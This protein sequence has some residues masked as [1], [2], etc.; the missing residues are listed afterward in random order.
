MITSI[1]WRNIWRNKLRSSVLLTAIGIGVFAGVF[2]WAFMQG[3]GKQRVEAAIK[4]EVAHIQIHHP[5]Y[6]TDPN[7]HNYMEDGFWTAEM[8]IDQPYV[9]ATSM[10]LIFPAMVASA[11][12]STGV[13]LRGINPSHERRVTDIHERIVKGQYFEGISRNPIVIG[14]KLA[15]KLK[16]KVRSK[17]VVTLQNMEGEIVKAQ[18]RVAGIFKTTNSTYDQMN[19]FVNERDLASLTGIGRD[20]G[21]EVALIVYE[22]EDIE[23]VREELQGF[24]GDLELKTWD[25]VRPEISLITD[26]LNIGMYVMMSIILLGLGFGIVNTMLMA[27]LERTKELGM[28]MAIGMNRFRMF[29]MILTETIFICIT[30][31]IIG[32]IVG[33]ALSAI[34]GTVGMD[35]SWWSDGMEKIG[36]DPVVFPFLTPDIIWI[37]C[38]MVFVVAIIA[39]IAPA[40]KA[41]KLNPAEAIRTD[42]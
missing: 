15:D 31:T 19:A 16:L 37:V 1:S 10:R 32:V 30:G 9:K 42:N 7:I 38:A 14:Q 23:Y 24:F 3:M 33:T 20:A 36:M 28:L 29:R 6:L 41:L 11:E 5:E 40:V 26:Q 8:A 12:T 22:G 35:L 34:Y 4:T 18:F 2:A 13:S 27:I 39:S 17:V 25:E 21:H